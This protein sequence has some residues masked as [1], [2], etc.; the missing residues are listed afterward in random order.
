MIRAVLIGA[1]IRGARAYAPYALT[2]PHELGFAAVAEPDERKRLHFAERHG[3]ADSGRFAS[4]ETLLSGPKLGDLALICTQ[5]NEHFEPAMRALRQGYHV[6]LE[7]P[8]S[9]DPVQT[10]ALAEEARRLGKELFVCHVLRYTPYFQTLK[11]LVD[12]NRIGRLMSVQW[13]E[14]VGYWHQAHSY[15]RGN[16]RNAGLSSPML[17]AKSCHDLDLIGWLL[18]EECTHVSSFGDLSY[19]KEE[20]APAGSTARCTD[21]C[22]VE[23]ECS[24]S[25]LKWYY[26]EKDE[27]P[28]NVPSLE[29]KL[30][31]RW[32]AITEGPYGRCVFRCDN[33]VVDHQIVNMRFRS[34]ATAAFTMTGFTKDS[35]RTFKLMGTEGEIRG[36]LEKNEIELAL[37]T[38]QRE[39]IVPP[40]LEGG[41]SGG[42]YG[43]VRDVVKRIRQGEETFGRTHGIVSA[44]SH[45]LVFAAEQSRA[46]GQTV[47]FG[48]YIRS[49]REQVSGMEPVNEVS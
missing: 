21:G 43:M 5:D 11:Q 9:P 29:P 35:S 23:A 38:G 39:L 16:W 14:N 22:A 12:D 24:Y 13:N 27:W 46:S 28:H 36:H 2:H 3:I 20:R 42:D 6:M 30:E 15:V 25:A 45:M 19:F 4:W 49:V 32:K 44:L 18:E 26:N 1:G 47:A 41:H 37:F 34:G 7:K 10:M 8:M 17:L 33:D 31:Q 48:E 40:K